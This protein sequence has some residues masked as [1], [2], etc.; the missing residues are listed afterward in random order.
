MS[1][2]RTSPT[3]VGALLFFQALYGLTSSGNVLR[4]P[5][6]F[7][8][9]FQVEHFVDAGNISMRKRWRSPSPWSKTAKPSVRSRCFR[10]RGRDRKPCAPYGPL[11]AFLALPHHLMGRAVTQRWPV[12]RERRCPAGWPGYSSSVVHDAGDRDRRGSGVDRISS[13]GSPSYADPA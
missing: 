6:E 8:V 11:V 4:V 12:C 9:Y 1:D 13:R 5:D 3:A 10:N 2:S 7:E